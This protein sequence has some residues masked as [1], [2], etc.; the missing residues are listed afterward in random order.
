MLEDDSACSNLVGIP[1]ISTIKPHLHFS[2]F[3]QPSTGITLNPAEPNSCLK[4]LVTTPLLLYYCFS[5]PHLSVAIILDP[6]WQEPAWMRFTP[7]L[8]SSVFLGMT[9]DVDSSGPALWPL[10]SLTTWW[11]IFIVIFAAAN[12]SPRPTFMH[13]FH[14]AL[15]RS[16]LWAC[17]LLCTAS[18]RASPLGNVKR[19]SWC[20][21]LPSLGA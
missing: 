19:S 9:G 5:S 20:F 16:H 6:K 18:T 4:E 2:L 10:T 13:A 7:T 17:S 21:L 3:C 12:P 8:S 1:I 15:T 11:D 14:V